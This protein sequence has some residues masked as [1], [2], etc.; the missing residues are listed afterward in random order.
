MWNTFYWETFVWPKTA[1]PIQIED[2]ALNANKDSL[3]LKITFVIGTSVWKMEAFNA[4]NAKLD[5]LLEILA[6]AYLSAA[7]R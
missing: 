7:N 6:F 1:I 4:K 3:L 2:S 5:I